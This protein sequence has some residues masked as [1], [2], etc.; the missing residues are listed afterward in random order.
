MYQELIE[1]RA[2]GSIRPHHTGYAHLVIDEINTPSFTY[3]IIEVRKIPPYS[4]V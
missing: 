3:C 2:L 4:S 1:E